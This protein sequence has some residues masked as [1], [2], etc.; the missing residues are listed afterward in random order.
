MSQI[1]HMPDCFNSL[2]EA[3]AKLP[4]VGPKTAQRN[5]FY[6]LQ[7]D[8]ETAF[9]LATHL[10]EALTKIKNCKLCN[11]L[12]ERSTCDICSN[13][14]RDPSQVCVVE[15]PADMLMIEQSHSFNGFYFVLMG[16]IS[17][18][19][20]VGP[21][22]LAFENLLTRVEKDEVI[23]II[24]ATNFTAE[25]EATAQAIESLLLQKNSSKR[26]KVARL[27]KGVPFG[28]ELEYTDLG[29]IA[30]AMRE[31]KRGT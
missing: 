31:R 28:G 27:A 25:G 7:F 23:E 22:E 2:T 8:R 26:K 17:F 5:A 20:G 9:D 21:K 4:G 29:T 15:S 18:I 10:T 6:L 30:Q 3:F 11:T 19:D 12:S 14:T 24:I 13:E 16:R 1:N